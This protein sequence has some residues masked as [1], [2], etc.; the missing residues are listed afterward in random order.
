MCCNF[1]TNEDKPIIHNN[2][3]LNFLI[4]I[5]FQVMVQGIH[6]RIITKYEHEGRTPEDIVHLNTIKGQNLM[7]C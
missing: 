4:Y 3:K 6:K 5:I 2:R 7:G 1:F